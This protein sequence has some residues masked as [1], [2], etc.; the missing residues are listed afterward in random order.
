M[1]YNPNEKIYQIVT[2]AIVAKLE[3]GV[4]PWR[5]P[6]NSAGEPQNF[7]TKKPYRG[8]NAFILGMHGHV[9][10]YW[11][12]FKQVVLKGGTVKKGEKSTQ[13]IYWNWS[14]FMDKESGEEK[15]IPFLKYYNVFNTDQCEGL[16]VPEAPK[17]CDFIPIEKC[18]KT[19][20]GMMQPPKIE[21]GSAACYIPAL[22]TVK[23][24]AVET[25]NSPESYYSVLFHE[26]AHSTGAAKRLNREGIVQFDRF[27]SV[28]YSEEEL[29]AEMASAMICQCC[30]IGNEILDNQASYIENWLKKFKS[31]PK[32][33]VKAAGKA[34][35]AADW[36]LVGE[37]ESEEEEAAE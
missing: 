26:L 35:K 31:D 27:G 25:F 30:G 8:I 6:W 34:Q 2:D 37:E 19:V 12:T 28:Q 14:K 22:D 33:L 10:P 18:E 17:G 13:I 21:T 32:M 11:L 5:K 15:K 20:A 36:L 1:A 23:M 4:I 16:V 7:I 24:P 3:K 9:S 29:I